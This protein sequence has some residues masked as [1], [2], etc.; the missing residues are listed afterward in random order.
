L[1]LVDLAQ[2]HGQRLPLLTG[3]LD[4]LVELR[5]FLVFLLLAELVAL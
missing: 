2:Q 3:L 1:V 4:L 5:I